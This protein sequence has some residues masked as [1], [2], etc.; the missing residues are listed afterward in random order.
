MNGGK[1]DRS[2]ARTRPAWTLLSSDQSVVVMATEIVMV[3]QT[4]FVHWAIVC[5]T[6]GME[7][8]LPFRTY[9]RKKKKSF[10]KLL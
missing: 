3:M 8:F 7:G 1:P 9:R 6:W 2:V 4:L 10:I 5:K